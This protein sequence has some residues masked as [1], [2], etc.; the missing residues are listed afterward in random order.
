[1]RTVMRVGGVLALA[2]GLAWSVAA[3]GSSG[4]GASS[5]SSAGGKE[6]GRATVI[7]GTAPDFLDPAMGFTNESVEADWISYTPLVTE[8]H[9]EGQAGTE[10]IPGLA[11]ALP[12]VS[13]D[14][15]TYTMTLRKGL[16]YSDGTPVKASDFTHAIERAIKLNWGGKSFFTGYIAGA[17]AYDTGKAKTISG[18]Q[19]DD[20]TG[21]IVIKLTQP[22]G[23]FT[24]VLT[25]PSAAPVPSSTPFKNLSN[26]PPPGVGPY[27]VTSVVPNRS[28]T[29]KK[30]PRFAAL[31]IP[32]IPLGH[33]D[34]IDVTIDTNTQSEA[35]KVLDDQADNFDANDTLP[36]ALLP[37]I[38][39]RAADRFRKATL[40]STFFFFLNTTTKPFDNAL[41]RE[42]VATAID[43][44]ALS[45]LASGFLTPTCF[46][47]PQGLVGHPTAPCPYGSTP[48]VV[49]ARQLVQQS[50]FKGYPVTVWGRQRSPFKEFADYYASVL[51]SIGFKV[52]QKSIS[53]SVYTATIGNAST[54]PQTG[55]AEWTLDFPHPS[56]F[57]L[58]LDARSIQPT[59][60][61]N[62]SRV[63]DP[64]IQQQLNTLDP[65]PATQLASRAGAWQALDEYTARKAYVVP[66]GSK[67]LPVFFSNR[68][69]AKSA[70]FNLLYLNDWTSWRL[71]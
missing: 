54:N 9:A 27:M 66:Y 10:I 29:V 50:G 7:M 33:L 14:G 4:N 69:D 34:A 58:L 12:Q 64:H 44:D 15:K 11:D 36:P 45:R 43:R 39:A 49:K 23:P 17:S 51:A 42:A 46:F 1:M 71:K 59:A 60:S 31:K 16:V 22:Y 30:N 37:Q 35:E 28:F 48:D 47:I 38:E 56:D 5:G 19:A 32:S 61:V 21:K 53:D 57:Y 13:A 26:D 68:I 41:A 2:V 70:V 20:A 3:C 18:I 62:Y 55:T 65:V 8:R 24:Y 67:N 63:N 40:P 6:G 52:T 25:F